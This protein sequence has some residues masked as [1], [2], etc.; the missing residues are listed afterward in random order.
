[1]GRCLPT[2][3]DASVNLH[4]DNLRGPCSGTTCGAYFLALLAARSWRLHGASPCL[5]SKSSQTC[6]GATRRRGQKVNGA[7]ARTTEGRQQAGKRTGCAHEGAARRVTAEPFRLPPSRRRRVRRR[8]SRVAAHRCHERAL[9]QVW[10][11]YRLGTTACGCRVQARAQLRTVAVDRPEGSEHCL[12]GVVADA[13]QPCPCPRSP[14][15]CRSSCRG[16][17][18]AA[19]LSCTG[20]FSERPLLQTCGRC[21]A[22]PQ[23][24]LQEKPPRCA[25][26]SDHCKANWA[27]KG[28]TRSLTSRSCSASSPPRT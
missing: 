24:D 13:A 25:P 17:L 26:K 9:A 6:E 3:D 22:M 28:C 21:Q 19:F 1:M 15:R 8:V 14:R 4:P 18:V 7:K 27:R 10:R 23:F 11:R 12:L 20:R 5:A 16:L 2:L